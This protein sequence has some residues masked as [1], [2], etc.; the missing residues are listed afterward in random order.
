MVAWLF[1]A[2]GIAILSSVVPVVS[3]EVFVVA[4]AAHHPHLPVFAFGAVSA[5]GQVT[6]KLLYFYA[7]R[8]SL[9]LPA[10]MHRSA[11]ASQNTD[12]LGP[13][14]EGWLRRRWH[15]VATR[16]RLVWLWLRV[17][18]HRYPKVMIAAVVVS[19]LFGIPP[20]LATTVLAGLAGLSTLTFVGASLPAR[21]L[22]FTV[23]AMSPN[24]VMHWWPVIHHHFAH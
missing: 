19:A 17:K 5:I 1:V 7:A 21:F 13:A 24:L 6:G 16:V 8:G 15:L 10:F 9:H 12:A 14:P 2:L 20:F 23:L 11:R 3:A 4:F 22:R 18:C